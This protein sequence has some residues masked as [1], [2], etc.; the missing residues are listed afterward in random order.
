MTALRGE[1][2]RDEPMARHT[3]WR[4][5][6]P[7]EQYYRPADVA[8]L[9]LFLR[10]LSPETPVTWVGLGSNLLVRDG[11]IRGVVIATQGRL[12]EMS[13]NAEGEI[14]AE[15]GVASA[16]LARF[17]IREGRCGL[18]F[19]AG[20]PGTVGGA[21]RMNAGAFGGETWRHLV[22]VETLDRQGELRERPA[23]D[24]SIAYRQVTGPDGEWFVAGVWQLEA[25]DDV[26]GRA[27]IKALLERRNQTQ[28]ISQPSCGSVFKNPPDD[29]AAR[30]IEAVGLKG[31]RIGDACVSEKHANFIINLGAARATDI[32]ALMALVS[33]RVASEFGVEL[34]SEVQILGEAA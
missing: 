6:G 2:L 7:A 3:T 25:G 11:G 24:F 13:I 27:E 12:N 18:E 8:D 15:A 32:E 17:S 21:L 29:H 1:L 9:A 20:I 14:R 19:L 34:H 30:L 22:Q 16:H 5:G 23:S 26:E 31:E 10:Q 33:E 4:V 28:P